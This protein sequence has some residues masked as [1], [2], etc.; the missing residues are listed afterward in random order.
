MRSRESIPDCRFTWQKLCVL[1]RKEMLKKWKFIS[2]ACKSCASFKDLKRSIRESCN[3][4]ISLRGVHSAMSPPFQRENIT[5]SDSKQCLGR[6][7]VSSHFKPYVVAVP[8]LIMIVP[9]GNC[10][11]TRLLSSGSG[12]CLI[13]LFHW[14]P[15]HP[16]YPSRY[17]TTRA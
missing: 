14:I 12:A 8:W 13:V 11:D 5:T 15:T 17:A 3:F 6:I 9:L 1:L 2:R 16:L 4:C 7:P 10:G